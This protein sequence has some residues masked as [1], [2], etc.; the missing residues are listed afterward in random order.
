LAS[1]EELGFQEAVIVEVVVSTVDDEGRPNAAPMG[2]TLEGG[3]LILRPYRSTRTYRDMASTKRALLNV[4]DDPELFVLTALKDGEA[5]RWIFGEGCPPR[6]KGAKA[7]VEVSVE[8]EESLSDDRAKLYCKPI[9]VEARAGAKAYCRAKAAVIEA[10]VH[11]TRVK[12]YALRGLREEAEWLMRLI[13]HYVAL[14]KRVAPGTS[15]EALISEVEAW[16]KKWL[17]EAYLTK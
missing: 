2:V 9:R 1:L 4:V 10:T 5:P 8:R 7:Y 13:E 17:R 6:L 3:W 14:V 15:Y 12:V 11:A 16:A